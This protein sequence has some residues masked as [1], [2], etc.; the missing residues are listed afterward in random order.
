VSAAEFAA[1]TGGI[2]ALLGIVGFLWRITVAGHRAVRRL[3][4][5]EEMAQELRPNGGGSIKD[6]VHR[7]DGRLAK[8]EE[9]LDEQDL[10]VSRNEGRIEAIALVTSPTMLIEDD[11]GVIRESRKT[12]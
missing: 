4:R 6:T 8:V 3:E 11:E 1:W 7:I 5:I 12:S 10:R 2:L 9:R